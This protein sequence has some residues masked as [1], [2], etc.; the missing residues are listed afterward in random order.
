MAQDDLEKLPPSPDTLYGP[1]SMEKSAKEK[2]YEAGFD[3]RSLHSTHSGHSDQST[4]ADS[5][6]VEN[7]DDAL[8]RTI[9]P[10]RPVVKVPRFEMRGLFARFSL[11]AEVTEPYDYKNNTKW[12][13]TFVVAVAAAAAPVGSAIIL[14]TCAF[15]VL[16]SD[17]TLLTRVC[18]NSRRR[19]NIS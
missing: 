8:A 6:D 9:T 7:A 17:A 14:R 15:A 1:A 12:F 3:N 5:V 4:V 13:I 10:K 19:G 16:G 2:E 18:S 11:M